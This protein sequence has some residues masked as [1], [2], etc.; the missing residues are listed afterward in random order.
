MKVWNRLLL[1]L[2]GGRL[3]AELNDEIRLHREMLEADFV[4]QG[5]TPREAAQA[6]ARQFG[7]PSAA[8]DFSRDE[9]TFPRLDAVLKDL[10]FACRLML[11][12]PLLTVAAAL[13]LALGVGANTAILSVLETVL[14][15]P[16]GMRHT[17]GVMVA[18]VRIRYTRSKCATRPIPES[19]SRCEI[20][21]TCRMPSP[22]PP[23][24]KTARGTIAT[25][26]KPHACW[27]RP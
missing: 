23:R 12:H 2:R 21:S 26:V 20:Q 27:G 3:E 5:M 14:L 19:S 13:T 8:A 17:D 7:N 24:W 9:W 1:R 4:R 15:N 18:R 22:P 25:A 6:A 10:R 16:L 11:R